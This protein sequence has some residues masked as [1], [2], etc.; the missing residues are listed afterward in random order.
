MSI[1]TVMKTKITAARRG[2]RMGTEESTRVT[3]KDQRAV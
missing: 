1:I 3:R 2:P